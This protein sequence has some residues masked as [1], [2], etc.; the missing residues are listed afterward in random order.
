M[1]FNS[2]VF[3][4]QFLPIVWVIYFLLNRIKLYKLAQVV[5]IA[6][7][8]FFYG[9]HDYKL[10]FLLLGTIIFNYCF[11]IC[12]TGKA[13][14][15]IKKVVLLIGI[16]GNLGLLFYY[17][18]LDFVLDTVNTLFSRDFVLRNIVLPLG[19]SFFTFQQ[20]SML[21]DSSK[22][23]MPRYRFLE[24]ALFVSFF[25]QLVAGPIVLH[26]EMIP[27]FHEEDKKKVHF[28]NLFMGL[29]YFIL[30]FAKKVLVADTFARICDAGYEN[31]T[32]LN[33]Y[34]ALVT[35]LTFTLQIYFDF[36]GYCDM[37]KGLAKLFNFE[38]PINFNSPYKAVNISEFWQRWHMTL[39][40]FL[41]QYLYIPLGGNRKGT[42]RTYLNIMIVFTISG[43]WHG[44]DWTFIFWGI[45]HGIAQVI[46]RMGKKG[47]DKLPRWLCWSG[48]FLFVNIAW[49]FFRA[50]YS[51]QPFYFLPRLIFGGGGFC[52]QPLLD[53]LCP[54][55]V[56]LVL[57]ERFLPVGAMAFMQQLWVILWLFA[58]TFVCVKFPSS[59]EIVEKKNRSTGYLFLLGFLFAWTFLGLTQISKFIY[60]NF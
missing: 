27:Q 33:I 11:H 18:Y 46:Y 16:L 4:V 28:D 9:Y 29:E 12:L 41:T 35:M 17:K 25:P 1:L 52:Q 24:Y 7:S 39:T 19:I 3:I 8:F 45:L 60:F 37:A 21:I 47:F 50:D 56:G 23:D 14:E 51:R 31:L 6:A 58:G 15:K 54:N 20:I 2:F 49:V 32:T 26:Q 48:N 22:P 44:A 57:L 10:C 40:R 59:H 55:A 30:G 53:A 36:S 42:V 13:S 34:S 43:I 38:M 5:L